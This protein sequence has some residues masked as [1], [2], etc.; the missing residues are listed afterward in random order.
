MSAQSLRAMTKA[1]LIQVITEANDRNIKLSDEIH[2]LNK[3]I[4]GLRAHLEESSRTVHDLKQTMQSTIADHKD[5]A[6]E[7]ELTQ[8]K[9]AASQ[10]VV[11]KIIKPASDARSAFMA[12]SAA[13]RAADLARL[14][15]W[16]AKCAAAR[17]TAM[18]TGKVVLV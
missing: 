12:R 7:L 9:L 16:N 5:M 13:A 18:E 4:D 2:A 10:A 17:K 6:E 1:E 15:A 3:V 11:E 14:D 8:Q